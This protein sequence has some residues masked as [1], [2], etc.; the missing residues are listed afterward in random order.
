MFWG[1]IMKKLLSSAAAFVA[2]TSVAMA[3]DL[4]S[5]RA[6]AVY[7]PPAPV[8]TW[9][10]FYF[11]LNAGADFNNYDSYR[12]TGAN[13]GGVANLAAGVRDP[14]LVT[15]STGFAGGGQI[16]Y[17]FTLDGG[18][19]GDGLGIIGNGLSPL[20]GGRAGGPVFGVEADIDATTNVASGLYIGTANT[21]S[22]YR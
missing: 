13:A 15:R 10:G 18:F 22:S 9:E 4:P 8:F 16:G 5:R 17:N 21:A 14:F 1:K 20:F 11:G 7:V 19:V 2:L 3:A 6:P 12:I